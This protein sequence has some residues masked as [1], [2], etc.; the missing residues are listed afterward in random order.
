M[1]LTFYGESVKMLV[2]MTAEHQPISTE[3]T[4]PN[5]L[6]KT[7]PN[8]FLR[9][10]QIFAVGIAITGAFGEGKRIAEDNFGKFVPDDS[11]HG[12]SELLRGK[13]AGDEDYY[14]DVAAASLMASGLVGAAVG[15]LVRRSIPKSPKKPSSLPT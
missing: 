10:L 1:G 11:I 5:H 8:T 2:N 15:E 3:Y 4:D 6:R 9:L 7:L 12:R 13:Q 14:P